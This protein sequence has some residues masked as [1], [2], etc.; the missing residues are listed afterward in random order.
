MIR[1][2]KYVD[3]LIGALKSYDCFG[4]TSIIRAYPYKI[5]D[6]KLSKVVIAVSFGSVDARSNQIDLDTLAGD[7]CVCFNIF[8]PLNMDNR[9]F[10]DILNKICDALKF[11]G[12]VGIAVDKIKINSKVQ[13]YELDA[14]VT[15]RDEI[16]FGGMDDE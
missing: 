4:D 14:T 12:I 9:A 6:T 1:F 13:A 7:I 5:K 10:S 8:V 16:F 3:E 15:F 11:K 2:D